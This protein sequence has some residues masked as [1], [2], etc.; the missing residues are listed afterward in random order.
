MGWAILSGIINIPCDNPAI[1]RFFAELIPFA[2]MVAFS[3]IFLIIEKELSQGN[4]SWN[5]CGNHLDRSLS[6]NSFFI[7]PT[8]DYR[9][10]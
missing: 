9:E 4:N 10:K 7:S 5:F 2:V 3:I 1:W 6:D 8:G